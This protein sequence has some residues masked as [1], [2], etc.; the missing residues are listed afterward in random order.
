M[1]SIYGERH[2]A[3]QQMQ[4]T[5]RLAA[6][7]LD[8]IV[9][10]EINQEHKAFIESRD[11]F[12]LSTVDHRGYP[13]C[14]YK[15]GAS[16]FVRVI[17]SKTL[18]FPSYDGNGMYLSMGN[19]A[20]SG[21]VGM[22]FIDFTTPHRVRVHGDATVTRSDP[23]LDTYHGA[24]LIVRVAVAEIFVNCARYIHRYERRDSSKYVPEPSRAT[25]FPQWKRIDV[26]QDALP[27]KDRGVAQATGGTITVEE[28]GSLLAKGES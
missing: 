8:T 20:E 24:E 19:I 15:G 17:D 6:L 21:K 16:G 23:L 27:P 3:M 4:D 18:A 25:P 12:F 22:L 9:L 28:Y 11:M 13:T 10:S 5:E 14:S 2:R 1:S 7:L 26:V